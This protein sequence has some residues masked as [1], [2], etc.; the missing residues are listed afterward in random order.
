VTGSSENKPYCPYCWP[1]EGPKSALLP[2]LPVLLLQDSNL[3]SAF[4]LSPC[5]VT[6]TDYYV[7]CTQAI[8]IK[9]VQQEQD[10]QVATSEME[11]RGKKAE[12]ES[13]LKNKC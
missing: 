8:K 2:F 1:I 3:L 11:S 5:M 6:I 10:Q 7:K 12:M 9:P 4:F 13:C